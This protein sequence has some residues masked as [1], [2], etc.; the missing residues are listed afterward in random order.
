MTKQNLSARI[1]A[2][3]SGSP[4]SGEVEAVLTDARAE[5]ER[6]AMLRDAAREGSL[7]PLASME[8]VAKARAALSEAEFQAERL[9]VATNRLADALGAA[10]KREEAAQ[11]RA[12][13]DAARDALA[14]AE[15]A[16]AARWDVLASEMRDLILAAAKAAHLA[17]RANDALPEGAAK[18]KPS[19]SI[20]GAIPEAGERIISERRV[21]LWCAEGSTIRVDEKTLEPGSG[22]RRRIRM[23]AGVDGVTPER[24]AVLTP[25]REVTYVPA[26]RA[27]FGAAIYDAANIPSLDDGP[28]FWTAQETPRGAAAAVSMAESRERERRGE[29]PRLA[30]AKRYEPV[31]VERKGSAAA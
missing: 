4:A 22:K 20:S 10:T 23:A 1:A 26:R 18:L 30:T 25:F 19:A 28:A 17:E 2:I 7:D 21:E 27:T 6:L 14:A 9:T 15:A 8:D 29:A 12:G 11:R 5:I 3:L 13:Y 31:P 16:L 24:W